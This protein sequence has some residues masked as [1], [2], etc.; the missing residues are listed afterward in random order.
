MQPR[1]SQLPVTACAILQSLLAHARRY[2][3]LKVKVAA[4]SP[5]KNEHELCRLF[6][7]HVPTK[8]RQVLRTASGL[9]VSAPL[10]YMY[11]NRSNQLSIVQAQKG[12]VTNGDEA[13]LSNFGGRRCQ[14]GWRQLTCF[15]NVFPPTQDDDFKPFVRTYMLTRT[16]FLRG[17][18]P[19]AAGRKV[20]Q[21]YYYGA[22]EA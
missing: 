9:L 2:R 7:N 15:S 21:S 5:R 4:R 3:K 16:F 11:C 20:N 22:H 19:P 18:G 17:P 6:A 12:R 10:S 14:L 8:I 13:C 1:N